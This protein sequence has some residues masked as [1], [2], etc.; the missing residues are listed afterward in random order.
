MG[1]PRPPEALPDRIGAGTREHLQKH[2]KAGNAAHTDGFE[3]FFDLE[4]CFWGGPG[5][6][7][8]HQRRRYFGKKGFKSRLGRGSFFVFHAP[9]A[10]RRRSGGP[11]MRMMLGAAP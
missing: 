2:S 9:M 7:H 11:M 10:P 3:L 5:E 4:D 8:E 1:P 6:H